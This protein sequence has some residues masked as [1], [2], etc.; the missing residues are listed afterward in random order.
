M[1]VKIISSQKQINVKIISSMQRQTIPSIQTITVMGHFAKFERLSI[2]EHH[3]YYLS[4]KESFAVMEDLLKSN[5]KKNQ[6]QLPFK[7]IGIF[8]YA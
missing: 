1:K 4:K 6:I 3:V 2:R 8:F 7:K 5:L